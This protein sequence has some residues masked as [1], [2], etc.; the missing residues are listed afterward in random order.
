MREAAFALVCAL[1]MISGCDDGGSDKPVDAGVDALVSKCGQPGDTGN[2]LG[3]G[4]YCSSLGDCTSQTAPL[5]SIL[6]DM[7]THFCTN[8]CTMANAAMKCGTGTT[9]TCNASNQCG[10]TPNSCLQ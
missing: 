5:C 8:T 6:G 7:E 9:C 2:E 4:K 1:A 10:C 3:I